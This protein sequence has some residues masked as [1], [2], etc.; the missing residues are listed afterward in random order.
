M[1]IEE[2]QEAVDA[3]EDITYGE[4]AYLLIGQEVVGPQE[5]E[6]VP[7]NFKNCNLTVNG[8]VDAASHII[9]ISN[10]AVLYNPILGGN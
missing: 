5:G 7:I 1:T 6:N 3:G 10:G 8:N 2:L 9:S 4:V